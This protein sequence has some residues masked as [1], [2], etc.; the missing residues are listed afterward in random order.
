MFF[1][2][3]NFVLGPNYQSLSYVLNALF[4]EVENIGLHFLFEFGLLK[5][6]NERSFLIHLNLFVDHKKMEN[7]VCCH[8]KLYSNF[9]R[10]E[11]YESTLK[12]IDSA[13]IEYKF[14]KFIEK[15]NCERLIFK[16]RRRWIFSFK[17][18][19][20][21]LSSLRREE[22]GKSKEDSF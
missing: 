13:L 17:S 19:E 14:F 4:W 18:K 12:W 9:H 1:N 2:G 3:S 16:T 8:L 15:R 21:F 6:S 22:S 11:Q 10:D 20:M 7:V 5:Y